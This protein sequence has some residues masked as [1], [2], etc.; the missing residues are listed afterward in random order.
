MLRPFTGTLPQTMLQ[1]VA[2][3]NWE[4]RYDEKRIKRPVKERILDWIEKK[5]GFR[6]GEYKNYILF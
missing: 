2:N 3:Q 1:R 4:F 6:F 5:T